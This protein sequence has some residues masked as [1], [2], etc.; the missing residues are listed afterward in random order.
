MDLFRKNKKLITYLILFL[1]IV[2]FIYVCYYNYNLFEGFTCDAKT[3][4]TEDLNKDSGIEDDV[5]FDPNTTLSTKNDVKFQ[6][7]SC[8]TEEKHPDMNDVKV[9]VVVRNR[10]GT[11]F[12][13]ASESIETTL[14]SSKDSD[15]NKSY[16]FIGDTE[17]APKQN[18]EVTKDSQLK[19]TKNYDLNIEIKPLNLNE[20]NNESQGNQEETNNIDSVFNIVDNTNNLNV[21]P[22]LHFDRKKSLLIQVEKIFLLL[23]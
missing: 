17:I 23:K 4:E 12:N 14:N 7:I 6:Y 9:N 1:I 19:L 13:V 21:Y 11:F 2:V 22:S 20:T 10:D 15:L 5:C 8:I 16:N 18:Q 3:T